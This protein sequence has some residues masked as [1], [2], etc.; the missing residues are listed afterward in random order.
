MK[1]VLILDLLREK[2]LYK[3][4]PTS[5]LKENAVDLSGFALIGTSQA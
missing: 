5:L 4:L 2:T 1:K 3:S